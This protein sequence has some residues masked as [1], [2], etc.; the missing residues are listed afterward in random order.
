MQCRALVAWNGKKK[1]VDKNSNESF[2]RFRHVVLAG[3][4][5]GFIAQTITG[6]LAIVVTVIVTNRVID[7]GM[8]PGDYF[9]MIE[10][11]LVIGG[12]GAALGMIW[13]GVQ[14]QVAAVRRV[15]FF[16]D[17]EVEETA[18]GLKSLPVIAQGGHVRS[19]RPQLPQWPSGTEQH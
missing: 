8:S 16:L 5:V 1:R 10:L 6:I 7:G 11:A 14:G 15:F 17:L 9:A 4:G 13:I 18:P 12:S 2:R 19:C 3:I